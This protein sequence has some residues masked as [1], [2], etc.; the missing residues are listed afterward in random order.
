MSQ[1]ITLCLWFD[2]CAE[3]ATAFYA[4]LFPNSRVV[5]ISRYGQ[6]ERGEAGAARVVT[7]ELFGQNIIAINGGKEFALT[8]AMSLLI[9]CETQAEVDLYW[10]AL[11]EGGMPM[12]CGWIT[13]RFG[14]T[15]QIVPAQFKRLIG[16]PATGGQVMAAACEMAKLDIAALRAA[17]EA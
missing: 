14:V 16:D 5:D 7:M 2:G 12:R 17:A 13:D 9:S 11:A 15:W 1:K 10:D 8:P 3:D 6:G 4:G